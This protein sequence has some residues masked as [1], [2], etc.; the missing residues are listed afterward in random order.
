MADTRT[1]AQRRKIMQAVR[2]GD[3][4]PEMTVRRALWAVGLRYRLHDRHLPGRPDVV[5]AGR[6]I[7][8]FVHGCFWHGHPGCPRHRIPKTRSEFWRAKIERNQERDRTAAAAL[9]AAGWKVMVIWGCETENP[10][11]VATFAARVAASPLRTRITVPS[12]RL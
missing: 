2:S 1:P 10:R 3:T 6:R 8:I 9:E 5:L 12:E 7:A 4:L 11:E